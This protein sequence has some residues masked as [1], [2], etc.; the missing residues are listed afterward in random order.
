VNLLHSAASSRQATSLDRAHGHDEELVRPTALELYLAGCAAQPAVEP[1]VHK[2][3]HTHRGRFRFVQQTER[4]EILISDIGLPDGT[5]LDLLRQIAPR[6]SLGAIALSAFGMDVDL[7]RSRAA[8][9]D[10]HLTKPITADE[11]ES[12]IDTMR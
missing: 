7:A 9:F 10:V 11:L 1:G 3:E 4:Y 12:A 2:L 6:P 8:G 5:G